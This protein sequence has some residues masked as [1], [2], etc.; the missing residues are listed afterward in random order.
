[1]RENGGRLGKDVLRLRDGRLLV[2]T[3]VL[4]KTQNYLLN[5]E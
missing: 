2:G 1:M 4:R 3:G 5:M